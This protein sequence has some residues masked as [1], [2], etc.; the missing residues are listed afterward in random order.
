ME[1]IQSSPPFDQLK[2]E[3][4]ELSTIIERGASFSVGCRSLLSRLIRKKER[5]FVIYQPYLG[6]LDYLSAEFIQMDFDQAR[7][8]GDGY[9]EAKRLASVNARRCARIIAIA[10]L[11]RK[12]GIKYLTRPL[13]SYLLWR[14]TPAKLYQL[15]MLISQMSNLVDFIGSIELMSIQKRTT[16]PTPIEMPK[17]GQSQQV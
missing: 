13:A 17:Q 5:R 3:K 2:A 15:A 8:N 9:N 1:S 14:V 10:I 6:T 4:A 7:L 16:D 12:L 11:N